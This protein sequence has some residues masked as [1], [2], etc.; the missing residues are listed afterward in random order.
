M[1]AYNWIKT[2]LLIVATSILSVVVF[3]CIH[4]ESIQFISSRH[5]GGSFGDGGLYVWLSQLM[6]QNPSNALQFE[7]NALYPYPLTRAW[8]DSFLLPGGI[9]L[10]LVKIGL[11][12]KAAYN[13]TLLLAFGMNG[14]A[15]AYLGRRIGLTTIA[16][17]ATGI[18]FANSLFLVSNLGHPQLLFFFWLPLALASVLPDPASQKLPSRLN[19]LLAGLYVSGAFYCGVYYAIF[20]CLSLGVIWLHY[21]I[22]RELSLRSLFTA[23]IYGACGALP[24]LYAIPS[25]MAIQSYFGQRRLYEAAHFAATGISYLSYS[26]LHGLFSWS[27]ELSHSEA[28]LSPGFSLIVL[29]SLLAATTILKKRSFWGAAAFLII[30]IL[31]LTPIIPVIK[32]NYGMILAIGGWCALFALGISLREASTG[33][34]SLIFISTMFFVLSLGPG[35]T[36]DGE[37]ISYSV[38]SSIY[39]HTPGLSAIRAIGRMGTLPILVVTL[40]GMHALQLLYVSPIRSRRLM[41]FIAVPLV[42]FDVLYIKFIPIDSPPSTP[43]AFSYFQEQPSSSN[44]AVV[45]PFSPKSIDELVPEWNRFAILNTQYALWNKKNKN[46]LLVNGYSGQRSKIQ[47]MLSSELAN[48]PDA[49]SFAALS[50]ICGI[51]AVLVIPTMYR[52]W[53]K[54]YFL[55]RLSSYRDQFK[56]Y[57]VLPD[58]SIVIHLQPLKQTIK[59][60]HTVHIFGPRF[61][62]AEISLQSLGQNCPVTIRS[63]GLDKR[64]RPRVIQSNTYNADTPQIVRSVPPATLSQGSPHVMAISA[65]GCAVRLSCSLPPI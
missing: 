50:S 18:L 61:K 59:A 19:W 57:K 5:L 36:S 32:D 26:S 8:S 10:G 44:Q 22:R 15:A 63:L 14:G 13:T 38:L 60:D 58:E 62:T 3:V 28:H 54:N 33:Y 42:F 7:T 21:A 64:R 30:S 35:K 39:A 11:S 41:A 43:A 49:R 1:L 4:P 47:N 2:S 51:D 23:A 6:I 65:S 56:S 16:S 45:I 48:F 20:T 31:L 24:I 53:N 52:S 40:V 29:T 9:I 55:E 25:Y 37:F 46:L 12:F 27:S 17:I 34:S